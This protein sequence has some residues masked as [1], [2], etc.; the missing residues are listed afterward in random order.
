MPEQPLFISVV[1]PAR[2]EEVQIIPT[3]RDIIK[4][5]DRY[6]FDFELI[7]I[8][9]GSTDGTARAVKD[10]AQ[11][12]DRVKIVRNTKP[13]GFGNAIKRGLDIFKG[14]AVIIAMADSSDD[15]KDM[16]KYIKQLNKGY[17]CCFG[18][19]WCRS[20]KVLNYPTHKY[21]LNRLVNWWINIMF[22]IH[23]NDTTN[24]FKAYR[25]ETIKGIAPI[26]SRHFNITVEMP[27]KAIIRGYSYKI[28]S[29]H[30]YNKRKGESN[31]KIKEMGSR[32][33][34]IMIYVWLERMMTGQDYKK[35]QI[36]P[37]AKEKAV[38]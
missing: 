33:L 15:P 8:D 34:F 5:F 9:D 32:Y 17:D 3:L 24:A 31:L 28:V 36:K 37:K 1:I 26:L 16:V 10:Y 27:L 4:T 19:R 18:T 23:Y 29:T 12:D 2:N 22:G 7:V 20:A 6:H 13:N 35:D 14:D 21:A 25:R 11:K 38:K 30:W